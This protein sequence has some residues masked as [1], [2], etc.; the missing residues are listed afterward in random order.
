MR[1]TRLR[2]LSVVLDY[3]SPEIEQQVLTRETGIDGERASRLVALG[4]AVRAA[5]G[6]REIASTRALVATAAPIA[7]GL[8]PGEA[9]K[10]AVVE[11]LADGTREIAAL[12]TTIDT[13]L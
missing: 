4:Q 12:Q 2:M 11:P 6:H 10:A 5:D 13:Y 1:S 8:A 3:P 9:A 7:A